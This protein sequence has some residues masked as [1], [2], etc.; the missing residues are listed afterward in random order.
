[1]RIA[2]W[3]GRIVLAAIF[4]YA[5]I[6]KLGASEGLSITI[7]RITSAGSPVAETIASVLPWIETACGILL[8]V[9]H[10]SRWGAALAAILLATF[11]AAIGW[12]LSQGLI[13]DCGCFG[14]DVPP[15]RERM[16]STLVRDFVLLGVTLGLAL[17]RTR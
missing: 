12:A 1:M 7:M 11:I 5:G 10:T 3:A 14:A 2:V 9:P 17:R 4:L 15:S 8:L 16:V 6:V 13:V